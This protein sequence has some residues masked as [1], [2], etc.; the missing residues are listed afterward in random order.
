MLIEQI[1]KV[2][3]REPVPPGRTCT[4]VIAYVHDKKKISEENLRMDYCLLLN[5][6]R[7]QCVLYFPLLG[8]NHLQNVVP[9]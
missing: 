3:W 8:P 7:R 5:Y 6:C 2:E 1:I 4:P 9:K